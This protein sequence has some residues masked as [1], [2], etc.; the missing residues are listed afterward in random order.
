MLSLGRC[1][2]VV[3]TDVEFIVNL[4]KRANGLSERIRV[5]SA[6]A[7]GLVLSLQCPEVL[8]ASAEKVSYHLFSGPSSF[9]VDADVRQIN[10][11]DIVYLLANGDCYVV[12]GRQA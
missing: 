9:V 6:G 10:R 2:E 12:N 1:R 3:L 5:T 7:L 8:P 4:E 11:A